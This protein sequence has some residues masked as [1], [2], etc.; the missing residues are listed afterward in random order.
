MAPTVFLGLRGV[1]TTYLY[2][3]LEHPTRP[4]GS[5]TSPP[6]TPEDQALLIALA[7]WEQSLCTGCGHPRDIA[8]HADMEGW[9]DAAEYVCHACTANS[10]DGEQVVHRIVTSTYDPATGGVLRDFTLAD[11]T[12]APYKE[13]VTR[14]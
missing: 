2:D 14:A 1:T 11:T 12:T 3:D 10:R 4:T 8:W 9:Y 7:R 5:V 13:G 6:Y